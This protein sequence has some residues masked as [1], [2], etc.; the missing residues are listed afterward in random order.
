[1]SASARSL[2]GIYKRKQL[3]KTKQNEMKQNEKIKF[4][5]NRF[6]INVLLTISNNQYIFKENNDKFETESLK[7][8]WKRTQSRKYRSIEKLCKLI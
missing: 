5:I 7:T 4:E 8:D 1:M 6:Q 3:N 2:N